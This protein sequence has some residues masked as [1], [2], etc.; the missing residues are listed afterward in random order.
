L[1]F[2]KG[3]CLRLLRHKH[4]GYDI[5]FEDLM[6]Q[7]SRFNS[8]VY[9]IDANILWQILCSD[10]QRFKVSS[11]VRALNSKSWTASQRP[12]HQSAPPP[13]FSPESSSDDQVSPDM[14]EEEFCPANHIG[15][16]PL[17]GRSYGVYSQ[18][19][20]QEVK[21]ESRERSRSRRRPPIPPRSKPAPP[22]PSFCL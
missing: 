21:S 10:R 17:H 3:K 5:S 18:D 7:M 14:K 13:T 2:W 19:V 6:M 22:K 8:H 16:G 4:D 11:T 15:A 9:F 12:I 1:E 20:K